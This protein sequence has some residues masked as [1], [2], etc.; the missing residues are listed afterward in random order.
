MNKIDKL[1]TEQ[2]NTFNIIKNVTKD[3]H[4]N[5]NKLSSLEIVENN[6]N[7]I[8]DN[9]INTLKKQNIVLYKYKN[10]LVKKNKELDNFLREFKRKT[11]KRVAI[12]I[13]VYS[14]DTKIYIG[15]HIDNTDKQYRK[16]KLQSCGGHVEFDEDF[17]QGA[18]REAGEEHGL[19]INDK[20]MLQYISECYNEKINARYKYYGIDVNPNNYHSELITTPDEI[21]MDDKNIN[22]MLGN[23]PKGSI[24]RT[25]VES[26]FL[27]DLDVLR[28]D[29]Y[30]QYVYRPFHNFLKKTK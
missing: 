20:L 13:A 23:F 30:K 5:I 21:I 14:K 2:E 3:Y 11:E 19:L 8:F 9:N 27:V 4:G 26:T 1:K 25:T 16:G 7:K 6:K 28:D 12:V 10:E 17:V 22:D 15:C 18:I 24:I 29:K